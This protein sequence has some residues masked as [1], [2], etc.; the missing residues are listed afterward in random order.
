MPATTQT[1]EIPNA[2]CPKRNDESAPPRRQVETT[3]S[4]D[5]RSSGDATSTHQS[6]GAEER[7][8]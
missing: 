8:V 2:V 7:S 6:H 3:P 1:H 4:G 5:A